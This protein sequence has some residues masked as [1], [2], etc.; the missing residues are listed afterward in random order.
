M[1]KVAEAHLP[2]EGMT[3][4]ACATRIEKNVRKLEGVRDVSVNLASERA[5]VTFDGAITVKDVVARIEK[6]GYGVP[7]RRIVLSIEGMTCAACADRIEKVVGRQAAVESV[8]VN[9]A[10]EKA[11]IVLLPGTIDESDLI[12]VVEKAGYGARAVSRSSGEHEKER[13]RQAYQRDVRIFFGSALLT[14]PLVV[15]IIWMLFGGARFLPDVLSWA[16]ATPVQFYVGWRFYR[17]AYHALRG[18]GA[19]MD[20]LVVLGTSAAYVYLSLIHI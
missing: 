5:E 8:H 19:N 16:L 3:C 18:R 10:S 17:G 9:L 20:V 6:T 14:L 2:I 12:R 1:D 11:H 15:Q 13:K 4:A 7:R